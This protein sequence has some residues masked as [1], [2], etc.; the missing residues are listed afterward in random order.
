MNYKFNI[1]YRGEIYDCEWIESTDFERLSSVSGVQGFVFNERNEVCLVK[2]A[3]K[4]KWLTL[5]GGIEKEDKTLED[6]FIREV[7]EEADLEIEDIKRIGYI[8]SFPRKNSN[9]VNFQARFVARV[10]KINPQTIDPAEGT[11]NER[12]FI[13]IEKFDKYTGWGENGDFQVRRALEVLKS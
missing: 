4:D 12:K 1:T 13:P 8:K 9:D 10:K 5:G 11:M 3:R 2:L 7:I 6:T